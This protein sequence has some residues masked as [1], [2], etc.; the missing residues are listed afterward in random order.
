MLELRDLSVHYGAVRALE[1]V[2][3]QAASGG[4]TA[5]PENEMNAALVLRCLALRQGQL[6]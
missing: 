3:L 6:L 1:G 5:I 4:I 2:S